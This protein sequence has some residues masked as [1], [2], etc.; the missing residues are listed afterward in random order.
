MNLLQRFNW[1]F[2]FSSLTNH[3]KSPSSMVSTSV[4]W[5]CLLPGVNQ[6]PLEE[7]EPLGAMYL[8]DWSCCNF[9]LISITMQANVNTNSYLC[10]I[11]VFQSSS[12]ASPIKPHVPAILMSPGNYDRYLKKSDSVLAFLL[13]WLDQTRQMRVIAYLIF[14][15]TLPIPL[16]EITP[17]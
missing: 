12:S 14:S 16:K 15:T 17:C 9:P 13:A 2:S 4:D 10:E 7:F 6:T 8:L 5:V 11:S 3:C 1:Y